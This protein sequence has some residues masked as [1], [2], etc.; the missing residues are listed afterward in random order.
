VLVSLSTTWFPDQT[1]AYQSIATALGSL[2][3]R[4]V[5]TTGGLAPDHDLELPPN[6]ELRGRV[7]HAE[8]MPGAALV[9]GHGGHST[10]FTALA[11]GL[12]LV[13]LPMHPLLDQPMIGAA[14]ARAGAG[15][16]LKR[17]A[18]P[19][20]IARAIAGVLDDADMVENARRLGERLRKADAAAVAADRVER[21]T[22]ATSRAD[23]RA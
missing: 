11:H 10:T 8:I 7:P 4:G 20:S 13:I 1:T 19:D 16:V 22:T 2:P 17:T 3:V 21:L 5:I 15:V 6:V 18:S 9:V 12:P 14:V 23:R